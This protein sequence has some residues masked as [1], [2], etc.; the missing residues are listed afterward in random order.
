MQRGAQ[1]NEPG[2]NPNARS[3]LAFLK[4]VGADLVFRRRKFDAFTPPRNHILAATP[5]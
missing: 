5:A 4:A 1:A 3:Q 2:T